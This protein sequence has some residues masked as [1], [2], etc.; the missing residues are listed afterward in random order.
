[1]PIAV[2]GLRSYGSAARLIVYMRD[3][4][5]TCRGFGELLVPHA[6][7]AAVSTWTSQSSIPSPDYRAQCD[8]LTCGFIPEVG[9][10]P[11]HRDVEA[12]RRV[13]ERA[14]KLRDADEETELIAAARV[15]AR[16]EKVR[17]EVQPVPKANRQRWTRWQQL[18][19][20]P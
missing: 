10:A 16:A 17:T 14:A 9:W 15:Q 6:S 7:P 12:S 8:T 19:L 18:R 3:A 1:M 2:T 4:G 13:L 11:T 20:S 5:L